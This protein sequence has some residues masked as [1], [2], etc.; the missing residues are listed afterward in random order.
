M[1]ATMQQQQSIQKNLGDYN[2][3]I[4]DLELKATGG[5]LYHYIEHFIYVTDHNRKLLGVWDLGIGAPIDPL[6]SLSSL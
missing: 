5:L 2:R 3:F 1:G 6:P 4:Q